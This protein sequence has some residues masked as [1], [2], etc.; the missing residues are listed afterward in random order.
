MSPKNCPNVG[1]YSIHGASGIDKKY[2]NRRG[3][4]TVTDNKKNTIRPCFFHQLW[5]GLKPASRKFC[6]VAQGLAQGNG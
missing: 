2:V 1:K 6:A 4:T 3:P 5:S